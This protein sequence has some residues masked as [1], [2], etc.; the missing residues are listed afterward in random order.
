MNLI[1]SCKN[2][3]WILLNFVRFLL[4]SGRVLA[5]VL[6]GLVKFLHESY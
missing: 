3:A 2:L 6:L 4:S 5:C 1:R